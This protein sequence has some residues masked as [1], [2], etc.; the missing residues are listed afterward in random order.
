M[1]VR[2][3]RQSYNTLIYTYLHN[4]NILEYALLLVDSGRFMIFHIEGHSN[5]Y[6]C[7]VSYVWLHFDMKFLVTFSLK[8]AQFLTHKLNEISRLVRNGSYFLRIIKQFSIFL[9]FSLSHFFWEKCLKS[10]ISSF[11]CLANQSIWE[12][13]FNIVCVW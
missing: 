10:Y 9:F 1:L 12:L 7:D 13:L 5:N 4:K 11:F 8:V 2:S 6:A 3:W